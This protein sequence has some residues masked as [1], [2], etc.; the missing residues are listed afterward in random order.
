MKTFCLIGAFVAMMA[1]TCLG[2]IGL[3]A[4]V[5]SRGNE[6][7]DHPGDLEESRDDGR[8]TALKALAVVACVGCAIVLLVVAAN[9]LLDQY[10]R[11]EREWR[12]W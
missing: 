4:M 7:F 12:K 2:L 11:M 3:A 6:A 5:D 1:L 9:G 8:E 10:S